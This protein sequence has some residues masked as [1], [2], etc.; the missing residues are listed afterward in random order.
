V[1]PKQLRS[2]LARGVLRPAYLLSGEEALLR[3]DALALLRETVLAEGPRDF[4]FDRFDGESATPGA[5]LDAVRTLPVMAERRLVVVREPGGQRGAARDLPDAIADAVAQLGPESSTVLVVVAAKVD[6]RARL[7]RAFAEPAAEVR[8][9]PPKGGRELVAFVREEAQRQGAA[10]ERS[11]VGLL[12]ERT[13]PQLLMLR[14]EI[15]KLSLL[16]GPGEQVT[17]SHVISATSE[18]ADE[19]VWELT[20][21]IGG[22]RGADALVVL[23][24]LLRSGAPPP[25]VL[26]ALV[27]HFRRLLRVSSGG[28]VSGPP[29]V[30]RKLETQAR[31]YG[32][33][34][35]LS[36]LRA[37]HQTDTA[38]KGEGSLRPDLALERLVIG[39]AG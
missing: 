38:L 19:P 32:R 26:G 39:L 6:R 30:L 5:L 13:G 14:Q 22:G 20:D 36:C 35:L 18:V 31:R 9:D 34:R 24:K 3:D 27:A 37:I 17:A 11:A 8:C 21:A 28:P 29:F 4:N 1:T 33:G 23:A 25:A 12:C 2:E 10:I 15:A 16:A 7:A